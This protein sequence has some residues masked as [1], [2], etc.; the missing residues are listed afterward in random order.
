MKIVYAYTKIG[1]SAGLNQVSDTLLTGVSFSKNDV[2]IKAAGLVYLDY[3]DSAG[4]AKNIGNA[5]V[6][7]SSNPAVTVNDLNSYNSGVGTFVN[8]SIVSLVANGIP[9]SRFLFPERF[10]VYGNQISSVLIDV[11]FLAPT[12]LNDSLRLRFFIDWQ[13]ID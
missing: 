13:E 2:I 8:E 6:T 3:S 11:G 12:A 5:R 1:L 7:I 9:I 4:M 10:V